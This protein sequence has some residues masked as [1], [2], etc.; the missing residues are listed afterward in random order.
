MM[1]YLLMIVINSNILIHFTN[2]KAKKRPPGVVVE[3]GLNGAPCG[4]R[5]HNTT[6]D[7]LTD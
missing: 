1:F 7:G 4:T 6:Y 3:S 2:T 5:T